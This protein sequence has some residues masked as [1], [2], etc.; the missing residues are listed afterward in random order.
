MRVWLIE[1]EGSAGTAASLEP[2]LCNLGSQPEPRIVLAG[3][4][5]PRSD[6]AESVRAAGTEAFVCNLLAG[7]GQGAPAPLVHLGLP[8]ML[9]G[10]EQGLEACRT[11]A[12]T[13]PVGYLTPPINA[14]ELALALWTLVQAAHREQELRVQVQRLQQRLN[15]RVVIDKAKGVLMEYLG[16][17]EQEA[18]QRLRGQSRRL[19]KPMREIGQSILDARCLL[20]GD[21]KGR[22]EGTVP[23][24]LRPAAG[25]DVSAAE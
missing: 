9:V 25:G 15:D 10:Q 8:V 21:D 23:F 17:G 22:P 20:D 18:Y 12:S 7:A 4:S 6:L 14:P 19:R 13:H 16:I 2:L 1:W 3:V 5:P 24:P 11:L